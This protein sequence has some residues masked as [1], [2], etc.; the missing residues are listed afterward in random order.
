MPQQ[1]TKLIQA[2]GMPFTV[3]AID[4]DAEA[5]QE[6]AQQIATFLQKVDRDFSPFK[7]NSLVSRFQR[8]ELLPGDWTPEL[9]TV[10]GLAARAETETGGAF[11]PYFRGVWDPTGVTKGWAIQEAYSRYLAP[12]LTQGATAVALNG[13][14]DMQ[15]GVATGCSWRWGV[16]IEDPQDSQQ[17]LYRYELQNA[18]VATSG[19]SKRGDHILIK[20]ATHSLQQATVLAPTLVVADVW[21]TA[22]LAMGRGAFADAYHGQA[23]LVDARHQLISLGGEAVA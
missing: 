23:L 16:G 5:F 8:G 20:D 14:G 2:M 10:Y 11:D 3:I 4:A 17:L 19:F 7:V 1:Q 22:A 9:H 13:A 6:A 15:M 12:L 21:A 18:A